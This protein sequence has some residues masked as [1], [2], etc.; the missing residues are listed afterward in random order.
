[1]GSFRPTATCRHFHRQLNFTGK[2][3]ETVGLSLRRSYRT[4]F[5]R[6]FTTLPSDHQVYGRRLPRSYKS[7]P[8]Q[9]LNIYIYLSTADINLLNLRLLAGVRP[10][11][12]SF[13][14][15]GSCVFA[16]QSQPQLKCNRKAVFHIQSYETNLPSSFNNIHPSP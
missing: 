9:Q 3:L 5:R 15:A 16:K 14:F 6:Q 2:L 7:I 13:D 8:A 1:M 11:T 10:Y 12:T 4:L